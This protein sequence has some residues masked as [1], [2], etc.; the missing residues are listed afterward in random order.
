MMSYQQAL[1]QTKSGKDIEITMIDV[2]T[3][4]GN[5]DLG[6]GKVDKFFHQ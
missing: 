3:W 1:K 4:K 5:V 6:T 2:L